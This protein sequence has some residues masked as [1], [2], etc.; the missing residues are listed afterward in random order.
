M[1]KVLL[2]LL[3]IALAIALCRAVLASENVKQEAE[4]DLAQNTT[5]AER[6]KWRKA[7]QARVDAR[8][9]GAG[10]ESYAV[11]TLK[12]W[13]FEKKA[14]FDANPK[15]TL[16]KEER[17]KL[18]EM[19]L[20]FVERGWEFPELLDPHITK[21]NFKKWITCDTKTVVLKEDKK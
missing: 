5:L 18:C 10:E 19:Y 3:I 12:D 15:E 16:T 4:E 9:D 11:D 17:V 2:W 8:P 7:W 13:L 21:D 20:L 1:D 6:A 14:S